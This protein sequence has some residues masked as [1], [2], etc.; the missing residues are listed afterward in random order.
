MSSFIALMTYLLLILAFEESKK[1]PWYW[2]VSPDK[3]FL[4]ALAEHQIDQLQ[5][6]CRHG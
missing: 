4:P 6:G 2:L 1:C 5:Q 3:D